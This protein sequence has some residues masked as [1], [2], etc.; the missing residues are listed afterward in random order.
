M[1]QRRSHPLR[2]GLAAVGE[3]ARIV[4]TGLVGAL[5]YLLHRRRR[6]TR[7]VVGL[8]GLAEGVALAALACGLVAAAMV[9]VDPAVPGLRAHMP[10][11]LVTLADRLT[12]LGYSGVLL[13]P[14]GLAMAYVL[15]LSPHLDAFSR[16]VAASVFARLSFVFLSV[17]AIGLG[18][19][20]VKHLLGRARPNAAVHLPGPSP[21]LTFDFLVWKSSFASFPSGH[22]TTAFATAFAI[23]ALY[24]RA[25]GPLVAL[26]AVVA[27]TRIVLGSHY[28]SDV[29]AG[30]AIGSAF[31]LLMVKV[32]AARRIVFAVDENGR[33][34]P[35]AGPSAGRLG[36][37]LPG[38][39]RPA[40]LEEARS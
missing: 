5:S 17:G 38:A 6:G 11:G 4:M 19:S 8:L 13:W 16:R 35:M 30:A 15:L 9:L 31:A 33:I 29:I 39:A 40:S 32:F 7:P 12:D 34:A 20:V 18:V 25:R 21:E 10:A 36:A 24:P 37:L 14:L 22:S 1:S 3:G 23:G 27:A 26:A 2:T 28:P